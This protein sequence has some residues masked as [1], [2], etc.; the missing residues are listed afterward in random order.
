LSEATSKICPEPET[1]PA[2]CVH[3]KSPSKL[4]LCT[5]AGYPNLSIKVGEK[6]LTLWSYTSSLARCPAS[7]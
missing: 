5:T 2:W 4:S 6:M 7:T 1:K 3:V